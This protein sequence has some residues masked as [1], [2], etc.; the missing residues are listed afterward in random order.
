M[1]KPD[2]DRNETQHTIFARQDGT[3]RAAEVG[4]AVGQQDTLGLLLR[5]AAEVGRQQIRPVAP[6]ARV[7]QARARQ[8]HRN[9]RQGY[10]RDGHALLQHDHRNI[11]PE[12]LYGR[13]LAKS[14]A[15]HEAHALRLAMGQEPV[16]PLAGHEVDVAQGHRLA[17]APV[18]QAMGGGDHQI[19]CDQGAGAGAARPVAGDVDPADGVPRRLPA[20]DD[21]PVVV[22][23]HPGEIVL[24]RRGAGKSRRQRQG[25]QRCKDSVAASQHDDF[26][27]ETH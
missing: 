8:R 7:H 24:R 25:R 27:K 5:A 1:R 23:D 12:G 13:L 16:T 10:R 4:V 15:V 22:A 11:G 6:V 20:V 26:G 19:G 2:H 21:A 14:M 9:R 18:E 17:R 3:A